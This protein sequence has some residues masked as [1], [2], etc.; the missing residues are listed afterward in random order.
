MVVFCIQINDMKN[1]LITFLLFF[2]MSAYAQKVLMPTDN[3]SKIHFV[4]KN[5]GVNVAGDLSGTKGSIR[6]DPQKPS[7][8]AFDV[9][10]QTSTIDTDNRRRDNHLRTDDFFD[11][12]KYPVIRL[13]S[14]KIEA[15]NITATYKFT[16][17]L[18]IKG[19]T[20]TVSFPFKATPRGN[21]YFFEGGFRFNR[22][23]FKLG[24]ESTFM[25]DDVKVTLAVLAK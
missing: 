4:I 13:A 16:G 17:L 19:I 25:S 18:T 24:K 20:R 11:V 10:V 1:S 22:L 7:S 6:F 8:S 12:A 5:F 3:G 2:C 21:G 15:T 14:T 9:T 23:D